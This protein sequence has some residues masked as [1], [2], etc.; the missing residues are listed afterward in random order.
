M[1]AKQQKI[2]EIFNEESLQWQ[3]IGICLI[4]LLATGLYLYNLGTES[5]WTDELISIYRAK[6]L[7]RIFEFPRPL[8]YVFLRIFMFFGYSDAWLRGVCVLFSLGSVFLTYQLGRRLLGAPTGLIG[9]LILALSPL[10]IHHA[11]EVRMYAPSTFFGLAGTLILTYTLE[12]PTT[13]LIL[14]WAFVRFLAII[15]TPLNLLL[16]LPDTVLAGWKFRHQPRVLLN[17]GKGLL[18][19]GLLWSPWLIRVALNSADFMG[20]VKTPDSTSSTDIGGRTSPGIFHILLQPGRF[21][22]WSFGRANSHAI[23]WFYNAYALM[24]SYLL[25]VALLKIK[26]SAKIAWIAAWAFLPLLPIFLVSQISR[27]LWVD[28]YILF[29][30]PYIFLLLAVALLQVWQRWRV[31]A[32]AIALIYAIA[33]SGGL[34][35][36]YTVNDREDWRTIVQTISTNEQPGDVIVWSIGQNNPVALLHY[37]QGSAEIEVKE[38]PD[39]AGDN[40][41]QVIEDWL[42]SLPSKQS[43]LWL[44]YV[45]S[46]PLF[47]S[48]LEEQ[49]LVEQHKTIDGID[50]FLLS[51][52]SA[53]TKSP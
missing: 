19:I 52:P 24:L 44:V 31:G 25:G 18:L 53:Q 27:S 1:K 49:F 41:E 32:L 10:F 21:T 46:S 39:S 16:L 2:G 12:K 17:F 30:A 14:S 15:T 6:N 40:E 23:Y 48:L 5:M 20:G 42:G 37:Y 22:A 9:A 29:V 38:L 7:Q 43:R 13:P 36:Y 11:Q 47:K 50:I 51:P 26:R 28:R 35:R 3:R 34:K 4:L 8:Y 45:N 33:I